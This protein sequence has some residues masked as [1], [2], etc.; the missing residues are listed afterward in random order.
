MRRFAIRTLALPSLLLAVM[1]GQSA[2]AYDYTAPVPFH[3]I[4]NFDPTSASYRFR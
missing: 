4:A 3:T 1:A 2:Q